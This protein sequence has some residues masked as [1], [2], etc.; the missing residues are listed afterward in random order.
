MISCNTTVRFK[1]SAN[2]NVSKTGARVATAIN[3]MTCPKTATIHA[4]Y[5]GPSGILGSDG[6]QNTA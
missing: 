3:S 1:N 5:S 4:Q 2:K 6:K